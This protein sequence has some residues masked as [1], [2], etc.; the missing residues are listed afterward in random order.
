[1]M[2]QF[3][4]QLLFFHR[5]KIILKNINMFFFPKISKKKRKL[6]NFQ[7]SFKK[8]Q[9]I[10]HCQDLLIYGSIER[11]KW[12]GRLNPIAR[13]SIEHRNRPARLVYRSLKSIPKS[14][15]FQEFS[16]VLVA[17]YDIIIASVA[18]R[19]QKLL[20]HWLNT[21]P[22]QKKKPRPIWRSKS[23]W[24]LNSATIANVTFC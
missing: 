7:W 20:P 16:S 22:W 21:I 6:Q 3:F 1:M 8:S 14:S 13:E 18:N 10:V 2:I 9:L 11:S 12:F 4:S 17:Y 24:T 19:D 5:K 23:I 15:I